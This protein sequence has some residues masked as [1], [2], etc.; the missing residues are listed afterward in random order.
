[1]ELV[2]D[3]ELLQRADENND[4]NIMGEPDGDA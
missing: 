1:M 3:S 4:W 2:N